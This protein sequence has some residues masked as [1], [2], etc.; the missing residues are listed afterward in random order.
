MSVPF[1]S[2]PRV[3]LPNT[4]NATP[5]AIGNL[6][7]WAAGDPLQA[8]DLNNNFLYVLSL[9]GGVRTLA[10][11]P[12]A[13]GLD[14]M[15]FSLELD[16]K[17]ATIEQH[18]GEEAKRRPREAAPLAVVAAL[19][20]QLD[21]IEG[22]LRA[23]ATALQAEV[24]REDRHQKGLEGRLEALEGMPAPAY[25]EQIQA[26]Q[27]ALEAARKDVAGMH[28]DVMR[29][30]EE[31]YRLRPAVEAQKHPALQRRE[32]G[33]QALRAVATVIERIDAL[34]RPHHENREARE[35]ASALRRE[36]AGLREDVKALIEQARIDMLR[37]TNALL[38]RI[39]ALEKK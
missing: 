24:Q 31:V 39:E 19:K 1:L 4:L 7:L 35:Q 8:A 25:P 13:G 37:A 6:H 21:G 32:E 23:H 29:L 9:I 5:R 28:K 14:A 2:Q 38:E 36:G 34:E 33:R 20:K 15:E 16:E 27:Q 26:L 11:E 3:V 22:P 17:I 12:D 30:R 18:L 10:S